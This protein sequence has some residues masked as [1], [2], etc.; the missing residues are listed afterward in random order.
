MANMK[1]KFAWGGSILGVTAALVAATGFVV[2]AQ[3][4]KNGF[5]LEVSPSP[6]VESVKPGVAKDVQLKVE[7]LGKSAE[8]LRV[9]LREFSIDENSGDVKLG[10]KEPADIANWVSFSHPV[11]TVDSGKTET[12]NVHIALPADSGFSYSFAVVVSRAD[13]EQSASGNT[14]QGSVA[15]FALINVD[16]PGAVRKFDISSFTPTAPI[17]EY[18]PAD[19]NVT[20]KNTGNTIVQ[21]SGNV[22]I[23]RGSGEEQPLATLPVNS[24][25]G[26]LLPNTPRTLKTSWT[27]G[28]P[29]FK[30][31]KTAD[32]KSKTDLDWDWSKLT[33]FRFGQYTAKVVAIYND[34]KRDVPVVSETTF[35]V[36]PWRALLLFLAVVII[37]IL[38]F[39]KLIHRRTHHAVRKALTDDKK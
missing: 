14:I 6:L 4:N 35:W 9:D 27:D 31:T 8:H 29:V 38:L 19:F 3:A 1:T 39:R 21:P 20:F 22:F 7:N 33:D 13:N 36:I 24:S 16:R 10:N 23:Q 5:A 25:Q 28:F 34:G 26:Y 12:E 2:N 18:L 11:F 32:G 15:V 30:T 37:V 17:F